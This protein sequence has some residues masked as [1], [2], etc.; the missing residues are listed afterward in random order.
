MKSQR[1]GLAE[2]YL[3]RHGLSS[4]DLKRRTSSEILRVFFKNR[5][6]QVHCFE[7]DEEQAKFFASQVGGEIVRGY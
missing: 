3:Y 2:R 6:K 5:I 4:K 1:Q 7:Q